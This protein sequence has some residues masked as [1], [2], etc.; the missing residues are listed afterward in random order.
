MKAKILIVED[1]AI[2]LLDLQ[3]S[4][5]SVGFK[6]VSTV[7][8]GEDAIQKAKELKP[9]VILMDIMLKDKMDGI[10][11][12]NMI[13]T[14]VDIPI[15]Y[16]TSYSDEN[17]FKRAKLTKPYGFITKPFNYEELRASIEIA[18]Y[19]HEVDKKLRES[20]ARF[21]SLYE[22]S[23][24]VIL[25]TTP[26]GSIL[27][28]NHSAEKIF[29]MGEEEIIKAGREG[30]LVKNEQLKSALDERAKKGRA[31]AELIYKRKDGSTFIGET[32]SS[33]FT[34]SDGIVKTSMIIRD[35]TDRKK[36]EENFRKEVERESFLL[37]LYKKA[38]KTADKELYECA[39]DYAVSLTDSSIG[40]FHLISDDQKNIILNSWNSE[41]L[42]TCNISFKTHYPIEQAGNW[43]DCI[44]ARGPVVYN[45]FKN[46]PN[47]KGYP[48][49]HVSVKRFISIPVFDED[50]VK[51]IFGVGNKIEEYDD[52]DVLQIQSV[53][54]ELYRIIKQRHWEYALKEAHDNL[55]LKVQKRTRELE[56]INEK[57][58]VSEA[59][60]RNLTENS[61][62]LIIRVD[63]KLNYLYVN[64]TIT[65]TSGKPPEFFIGK[66]IEGL[67]FPEE[68]V[69]L[70]KKGYQK[71]FETGKLHRCEFELPTIKGLITFESIK[72]PEFNDE[73]KIET[74][75]S[76]SYDITKRKQMEDKLKETIEELKRSNDEL[77]QFAYV[78]SHDLQEPLRTIASFTQLLERR[79][80]G[81]LDS[82]ADEFI[83]YIVDA[84]LRMKQ[85]IQDLLDYSR[86]ATMGGEFKLVD[87]NL[88]LNET[89]QVLNASIDES[90]ALIIVDE[91]PNV[92]GDAGQL[93][94][95][96]QNLILNAIKFRKPQERPIIHI[97]S[98][99]DEESNEYVF[100]VEDNGIGIENQY[101]ERI[102]SI[103]QRLHTIDEYH[104]TGIGL[105]IVKRI[106][107]RHGG[108]IWVE[109][110]PGKGSTFYFTIP[111]RTEKKG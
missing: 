104:G 2:T 84:A 15:I 66:N 1:E 46:S 48:E 56:G 33:I 59:Q 88:I 53:A 62:S 94:R 6:V 42:K 12:A 54:N 109:S 74:A 52:H 82:D 47:R 5:E 20:E 44:Q 19:K 31:Q 108:Y 58:R 87:L 83:E 11:A 111:I 72:I 34:D 105:S 73:G 24:D 51:F 68:I 45:D 85:Q 79:Y 37:N 75:I 89:I 60:F 65:E 16:M 106:I 102:F 9:D 98:Y 110:E 101:L 97:S 43:T 103:F 92:M 28:A 77:Q 39:L 86:V 32:T 91:L 80:K 38:P 17:T 69:S 76:I 90:K 64:P 23:F 3:R 35:I 10:E 49:G 27:A 93:G 81:K 13:S 95:V 55:E 99:K 22:N 96:F 26:D 67:G 107:E 70:W 25:L 41:A 21:H 7:S 4:L 40:F 71:T 78:S 50:K 18:I 14:F 8:T 29:D 36:A 57:L 100:S 61:P 63:K 30:L